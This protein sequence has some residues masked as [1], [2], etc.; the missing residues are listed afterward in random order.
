MAVV[1]NTLAF[2]SLQQDDA[3]W[4]LLNAQN[5]AVV[6]AILDE[7]LGGETSK[8]TVTDLVGLVDADLEELRERVPGISMTRSANEYCDSGAA[9]DT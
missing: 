7:H 2:K 1:S 8:R 6:I 5:A 3:A 4:K 9:T